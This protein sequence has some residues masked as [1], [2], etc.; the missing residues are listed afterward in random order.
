MNNR[1]F[2]K[3]I[4]LFEEQGYVVVEGLLDPEGDLQPV[5]DEYSALLDRLARDWLAEGKITS[6]DRGKPV[7]E[8]LLH[9][10]R[11]TRGSCHQFLD[12]SLP[13]EN[14]REDCPMHHG[15]A[16]FGLLTNQRLL[17]AVE[18]FIGPEIYSNPVQHMR[19]KPPEGYIPEEGRNVL[20]AKTFWHQDLG[21]I[22]EEAD[23]S[24]ILNVFIPITEANEENGC[25]V[26][27]PGSHR[28][29]LV[30]HCRSGKSNGIPEALVGPSRVSVE[31]K[32]GDVLFM[33]K[34]TMHASLPNGS[35]GVRWSFDLRYVPTG[36]PTG[37]P[38]F[39]GFVAR[40][41]AN[42]GS[43]L[44]DPAVWADSWR[45]AR[46][47]L[48]NRELPSFARWGSHRVCP[49]CQSSGAREEVLA[50]AM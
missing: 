1:R 47:A 34:L 32:P 23:V 39:P 25:V 40:S 15:P 46:A 44:A 24:N 35:N 37:R 21:V 31:M 19:V 7:C 48:A 42:P 11:E 5:V 17:D 13:L 28:R 43:E 49:F 45:Q 16:V 14:I 29:G 38:W 41:R 4:R 2:E 12:I 9:V 8:R 26:V 20:T 30:H 27:V 6:Y 10:M 18:E 3:E 50:G 36:Q 33:D 22:A